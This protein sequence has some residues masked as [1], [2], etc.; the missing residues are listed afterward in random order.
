MNETA[1]NHVDVAFICDEGFA[2]PTGVALY[3]LFV[4]RNPNTEYRV[5]VIC[6]NLSEDHRKRLLSMSRD[7][8]LI[9][10]I[11]ADLGEYEKLFE[12]AGFP[13]SPTATLKFVLPDLLNNLEKV[14]YIDGD[15]II[16]KDLFDLYCTDLSDRYVA[17][18]ADY[19]GLTFKGDVWTR[20]G[21]KH[22]AYFNSGMLVLNL[23]KMRDDDIP[24]AL[25]DYRINGINYYMDQDALNVVL[26]EKA[27]F[28]QFCYNATLTN[29]RNKSSVDLAG[30]YRMPFKED[31]CDYLREAT[32][33]HYCSSD[34]PWRYFD[35]HYADVWYS[36]FLGSPYSDVALNRTSLSCEIQSENVRKVRVQAGPTYRKN[37]S[38]TVFDDGNPLVSIVVPVYNSSKY[39]DQCLESALSQSLG[40]IEVICVDDGSTDNSGAMLEVWSE[41]D[42]RVRV[43]HQSNQFAGAAR[44][45]AISIARGRYVVF[46]DSDDVLSPVAIERFYEKSE[47][48]S[49][50]VA[51]AGASSFVDDV[52]KAKPLPNWLNIDLIPEEDPFSASSVYPY[53]FNFT[54]GGPG[55]KCFRKSFVEDKRL[56][57][58]ETAKSE[59]FF[60]IHLGIAEADSIVAIDEPLYYIRNNPLSLEHTKDSNPLAFWEAILAMQ[61]RLKTDGLMSFVERSFVN[62]NV[63]R[64]AFNIKALHTEQARQEVVEVLREN[65]ST[66]L[67]LGKYPRA[68]YYRQDNYDFLCELAGITRSRRRAQREQTAAK[69]TT[70]AKDGKATSKAAIEL[71]KVRS[72]R[73]YKIGRAITYPARKT[74]GI[75]RYARKKGLVEALK[76]A[77]RETRDFFSR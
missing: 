40:S 73:S 16:Q 53:V 75:Y 42:S 21:V 70:K 15:V 52:S 55:G 61:E 63:N 57:F 58:L 56:C 39:L 1:I 76:R 49:A 19:H 12:K 29:W 35:S 54:T 20:L 17:A 38:C 72:S 26:G 28:L 27:V 37:H 51:V 11:D 9:T 5:F 65:A 8:F 59:D 36:Y 33:V 10:L 66:I 4:S 7:A 77:S 60:F 18:V 46:L 69:P 62:E 30:Y 14:I 2:L 67:G 34:K 74:R 45:R 23:K 41:I 6:N 13:V 3:S 43:E 47:L 50:D 64:F 22:E 24:N 32:M 48:C 25:I 31:K 71:E 68:F 44:N